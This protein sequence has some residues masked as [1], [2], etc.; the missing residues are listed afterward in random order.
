MTADGIAERRATVAK[1]ETIPNLT[2]WVGAAP[3][4][5]DPPRDADERVLPYVVI[6]FGAPVRTQKERGLGLGEK[7]QPHI[8]TANVACISGDADWSMDLM[9]AIFDLLV[10]W[11]PSDTSDPYDAQGGYGSQRTATE[12]RPAQFIEGLFLQ[13]TVNQGLPAT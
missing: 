3:D 1:I 2:V 11:R 10:D 13:T 6:D 7:G 9:K 8:L 4:A 5:W 12:R